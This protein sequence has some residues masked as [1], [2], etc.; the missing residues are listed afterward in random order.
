MLVLLELLGQDLWAQL[1][2][3]HWGISWSD[4][5]GIERPGPNVAYSVA[6]FWL[7]RWR[8][9]PD[10]WFS[11]LLPCTRLG[12]ASRHM[13]TGFWKEAGKSWHAN[14][15]PALAS[16]LLTNIPLAKAS[17]V[18]KSRVNVETTQGSEYWRAAWSVGASS[19]NLP[20]KSD[21]R[22]THKYILPCLWGLTEEK[23]SGYWECFIA[24][25]N[26]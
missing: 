3:A 24:H 21:R 18:V 20:W 17:H 16:C 8:Y 13:A 23:P 9:R 5:T 7:L 11:S 14:A 1:V 19:V 4:S 25:P 12:W 10:P 26:A 2:S 6:I 15:Y 22:V